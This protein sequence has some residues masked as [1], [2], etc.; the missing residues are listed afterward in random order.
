M[1][2]DPTTKILLTFI[3]N[4]TKKKWKLKME[5]ENVHKQPKQVK[6]FW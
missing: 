5:T 3:E 1:L 6:I 4:K 2:F